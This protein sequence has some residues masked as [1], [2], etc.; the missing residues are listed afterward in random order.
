MISILLCNLSCATSQSITQD[1]DYATGSDPESVAE[2]HVLEMRKDEALTFVPIQTRCYQNYAIVL[3]SLEG[4]ENDE[5]MRYQIVWG[6]DDQ[7]HTRSSKSF[8]ADG[9]GTIL[10]T[11]SG[12]EGLLVF[13]YDVFFGPG[14]NSKLISG[15][16]KAEEVESVEVLWDDGQVIRAQVE[17]GIFII[18]TH[19]GSFVSIRALDADKAVLGEFINP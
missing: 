19:T 7:W 18:V 3:Y 5:V 6:R 17:D 11:A 13:S 8:A 15:K 12:L 9:G 14:G 4:S 16:T 2:E 10:A 1:Q